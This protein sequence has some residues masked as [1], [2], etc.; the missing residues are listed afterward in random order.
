MHRWSSR[1]LNMFYIKASLY[2]FCA[3]PLCKS[4][5]QNLFQSS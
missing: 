5:Y 3:F 2:D 4:T 1:L